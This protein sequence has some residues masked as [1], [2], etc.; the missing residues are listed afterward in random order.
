MS[1]VLGLQASINYICF[2]DPFPLIFLVSKIFRGVET[3]IVASLL[4]DLPSFG[5]RDFCEI[6][7]KLEKITQ[8]L[9]LDSS[10]ASESFQLFPTQSPPPC[11][12]PHPVPIPAPTHSHTHTPAPR[13]FLCVQVEGRSRP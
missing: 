2:K 6:G 3:Q 5:L 7:E 12:H 4:E 8:T 13:A 1:Q 10:V 11:L 9:I